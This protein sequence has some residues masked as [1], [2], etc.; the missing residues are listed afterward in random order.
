MKPTLLCL[1][2]FLNC[3]AQVRPIPL[4]NCYRIVGAP[5]P[6]DF[7]LDS[8][9]GILY[10]SSHNR[11]NLEDIGFIYTVNLNDKTPSL[12]KLELEYPKNFHPHGLHFTKTSDG[13]KLYVISHTKRKE[14]PH[15]LEIFHI[16]KEI[17]Q[18][19]KTI[20][21]PSFSHPNDLYVFEDGRI[22]VSNDMVAS[23]KF[24]E[25]LL[26]FFRIKTGNLAYFD[27]NNWLVL[28]PRLVFSNGIH[29]KKEDGKEM[30]YLA[31]TV[32][33]SI[34]K[35]ELNTKNAMPSVSLVKKIP[36]D[37]GP[38]NFTEDENGTLIF[39]SHKSGIRFLR[40]ASDS[41]NLS[42]S[43][44]FILKNN[45]T[46]KEVYANLGEEISGSSTALI[47]K[48]KLYI[49]QVFEPFLLS[50]DLNPPSF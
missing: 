35:L 16:R 10:V 24:T 36:L 23:S 13:K 12:K 50:C 6:E 46:T 1:F 18:L 42:P 19:E 7:A 21:D 38:D 29:V 20:Y 40:H 14:D 9:T 22:L 30:I 39:A 11:R 41:K 25:F 17:V 4:T 26:L 32:D 8:E 37:T 48:N 28:Q 47:Y 2:V 45:G 44:V 43:Q 15:T 3:L 5:G 49:S 34:L 27:K 33:E 31:D